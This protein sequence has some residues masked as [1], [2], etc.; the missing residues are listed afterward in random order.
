MKEK[1]PLFTELS[2]EESAA[3]SGGRRVHFD[4]DTYF[5]ILGAAVLFGNPGITST[6]IH[7]AWMNS[8]VFTDDQLNNDNSNTSAFGTSLSRSSRVIFS[9]FGSV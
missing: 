3:I 7:F 8:F 6:E 2:S 5:Y 9:S 4:L 1:S